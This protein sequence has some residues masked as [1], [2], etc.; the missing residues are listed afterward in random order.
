VEAQVEKGGSVWS[1]W[2]NV[3]EVRKKYRGVLIYGGFEM[4][5]KESEDVLAW[6]REGEG[7]QAL[8][9]M[10]WK[11]GPVTWKV[12]EKA[13]GVVKEENVR[14]KNYGEVK[15]AEGEIVLRKW[16]AVLFVDE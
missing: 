9:V 11:E 12:P 13:R 3:L 10:N 7:K 16:E 5:D 2:K 8:V 14:L 4:L 1:F 15:I 6:R